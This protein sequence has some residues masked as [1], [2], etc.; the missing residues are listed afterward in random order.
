MDHYSA[1]GNPALCIPIYIG[2]KIIRP[3]EKKFAEVLHFQQKY[4]VLLPQLST[5]LRQISF[6]FGGKKRKKILHYF[7]I[8]FEEEK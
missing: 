3:E 6:A 2:R 4:L 8:L 5:G 7:P 1:S